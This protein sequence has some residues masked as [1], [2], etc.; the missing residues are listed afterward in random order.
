MACLANLPVEI[1]QRIIRDTA[2]HEN[3]I[4]NS[5]FPW[6]DSIRSESLLRTARKRRLRKLQLLSGVARTWRELCITL[7]YE[8]FLAE[9]G[10]PT[11]L[12]WL[13]N[14]QL[15]RFPSLF[16]RTRR[17]VVHFPCPGFSLIQESIAPFLKLVGEMPVLRDLAVHVSPFR[18]KHEYR[19]LEEGI[20][21]ALRL[22]GSRLL[23]LQIQEP[24]DRD[25]SYGCVLTHRSAGTLSALAPNLTRL[26]C[27][28]EVNE[29]SL[30]HSAPNFPSLQ[31]LHMQL[32]ADR[33]QLAFVRDW[34]R[35]WRLGALKQFCVGYN[36]G[37]STWE[38]VSIFLAGSN[39]W[40]IN[41]EVLDL[42]VCISLVVVGEGFF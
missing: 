34:V 33:L 35:R 17:L 11:P 42:G 8:T 26:I 4:S 40:N 20:L 13:L 23:L 29:P 32:H 10:N 2:G 5:E 14:T 7:S 22:I 9:G 30:L 16:H 6:I 19:M 21:E 24:M 28:I 1:W 27:A 15:Y 37:P 12:R 39:G 25:L 38:W 31:T 3:R 18:S 41:L 36:A